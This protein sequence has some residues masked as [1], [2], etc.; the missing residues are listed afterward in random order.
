M[1]QISDVKEKLLEEPEKIVELL[2][3]YNFCHINSKPQEIRCSRDDKGGPNIS[4]RLHNN[5]WANVSDYA[6]GV[7][8]DIFSFI[9]QERGV[10]FREVLLSTKKILGLDDHWEPKKKHQLFNGIYSNIGKNVKP[11]LQI[12]D[13]SILDKY[14][15][16]PNLR[17]L[18]DHISLE[19]QTNFGIR[20]S[21]ESQRILIPVRDIFGNLVGIKSRRNYETDNEEDPKYK[22]EY[23]TQKNLVL[24]GAHENYQCLMNADKIAIF[25]SEKATMAADSFNYN[26]AVSLMGNTLSSEQAKILLS[27]NAKEYCFMLDEGLDLSVTYN[28]AKL[29]KSFAT[30]RECKITYFDWRDSLCVG[31]KESPTDNG[32]ENFYYILENEIKDIEELEKEFITEETDDDSI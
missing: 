15:K 29:L 11:E 7:Y 26:S 2:E 30:M 25:E 20:Y 13:E 8:T 23:P 24:Y 4:I 14:P 19:S 18:K 5:P 6:R 31:E 10:T 27:F 22:Y 1:A 3:E 21:V 16:C 12:Y 28:N 9:A 32:K 17:F